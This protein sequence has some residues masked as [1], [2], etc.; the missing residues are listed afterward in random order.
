MEQNMIL[1]LSP[2]SKSSGV[3]ILFKKG[4]DIEPL[5]KIKDEEGKILSLSFFYEKQ[6]FQITNTYAPTNPSLRKKFYK[7]LS[8]HLNKTNNQNLMLAGDLN[9][10]EDIYLDRQGGTPSNSHLLGLIRLQKIKQK[11]NLKD[12]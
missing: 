2:K 10:V 1:A 5:N 11:Y 3:I 12:T 6:I 8:Q 4:I 9:M 7:N